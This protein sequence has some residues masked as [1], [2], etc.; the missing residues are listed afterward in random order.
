MTDASLV[1]TG[2]YRDSSPSAPL[3]WACVAGTTAIYIALLGLFFAFSGSIINLQSGFIICQSDCTDFHH[4]S[5]RIA[6]GEVFAPFGGDWHY[7]PMFRGFVMY[8]AAL[9]I[10][11]G[12]LWPYAFVALNGAFAVIAMVWLAKCYEPTRP[13]LTFVL[14]IGLVASNPGFFMLSKF[15]LSDYVFAL[16]F[17]VAAASFACGMARQQNSALAVA[18][19]TAIAAFFVRPN[20]LFLVALMIGFCLVAYLVRGTRRKRFVALAAAGPV[21]GIAALLSLVTL[22]AVVASSPALL[23]KMP[24]LLREYGEVVLRHN[25]L[26]S[27]GVTFVN[28]LGANLWTFPWHAYSLNDGSWAGIFSSIL[29][30]ARALFQ[31]ALPTYGSAH[32]LYRAAYYGS[33]YAFF[34]LYVAQTLRARRQRPEDLLLLSFYCGYVLIF[35]SISPIEIRYRLP[36]EF[37]MIFGAARAMTAVVARWRSKSFG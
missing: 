28:R 26:G 21:L 9:K 30:R 14:A 4:L 10:I 11:F 31:I 18:A 15:L 35:L 32:N 3:S 16:L 33:L 6:S 2:P 22:T 17:G 19:C 29:E 12:K 1:P 23:D 34:L 36:I 20:G 8:V 13:T 25:V 37:L 7:G 5:D 27:D 24:H